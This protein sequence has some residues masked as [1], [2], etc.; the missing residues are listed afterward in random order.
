MAATNSVSDLSPSFGHLSFTR[1]AGLPGSG[2]LHF[3]NAN[4]KNPASAIK[5]QASI[6]NKKTLALNGFTP[7]P[8]TQSALD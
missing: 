1:G 4:A 6:L 7:T 5:M 3:T 2:V 8:L